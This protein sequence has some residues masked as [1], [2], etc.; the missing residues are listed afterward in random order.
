MSSAEGIAAQQA[1]VRNQA[2]LSFIKDSASQGQEI[3]NLIQEN[4]ESLAT[5]GNLGRN[6][7]IRV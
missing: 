1:I 4:S 5:S 3:A 6:V 7:N 2:T